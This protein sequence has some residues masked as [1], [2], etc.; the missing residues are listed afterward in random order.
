MQPPRDDRP[1]LEFTRN[2][3]DQLLRCLE[4]GMDSC[5]ALEKP[6]HAECGIPVLSADVDV[7]GQGG[8]QDP[9]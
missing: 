2:I 1:G 7:K 9:A 5:D 4:K 6:S 3:S 8:S